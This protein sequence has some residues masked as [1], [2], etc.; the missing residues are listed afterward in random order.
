MSEHKP[1]SKPI[2]PDTTSPLNQ[3]DEVKKRDL[4]GKAVGPEYPEK[5]D[6]VPSRDDE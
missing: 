5:P 3:A 1:G 6:E 2:D 4:P